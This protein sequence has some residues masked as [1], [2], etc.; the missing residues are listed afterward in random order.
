M[1][2]EED[3]QAAAAS[4]ADQIKAS[5]L[6]LDATGAGVFFDDEKAAADEKA[7]KKQDQKDK[8]RKDRKDKERGAKAAEKEKVGKESS[9]SS[10]PV[11]NQPPPQTL[12]PPSNPSSSALT[13]RM[14]AS[15]SA[16]TGLPPSASEI[17][18]AFRWLSNHRCT[19]YRAHS[20]PLP[21]F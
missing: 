17:D 16:S 10:S 8:D 6:L 9:F 15:S 7:R 20:P 2:Y 11:R 4:V 14:N 18:S 19:P 5:S 1:Q 13:V 3:R 21:S 12:A